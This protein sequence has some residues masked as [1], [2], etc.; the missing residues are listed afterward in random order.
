MA[1][2]VSVVT[3]RDRNV[4]TFERPCQLCAKVPYTHFNFFRNESSKSWLLR[5]ESQRILGSI[6][7]RGKRFFSFPQR[8]DAHP[9]TYPMGIGVSLPWGVKRP[10]R[11]ADHSPPFSVEFK[12]GEATPPL[13]HTSSWHSAYLAEDRD[14]ITFTFIFT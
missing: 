7:G 3:F 14:N 1:I 13:P 5:A 11:E 2:D 10:R 8:P 12:S 4:C 9:S 6:R